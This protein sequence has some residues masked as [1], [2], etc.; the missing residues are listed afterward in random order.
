M[1]KKVLVPV[2][3]GTEMV[4]ALCIVDVFRRAGIQVDIASVHDLLFTSS[5]GVKIYADKLIS[6]CVGEDYD[7][8][9]IPGG[10]PGAEHLRDSAELTEML[11]KQ[12]SAG[13]LYGAI[14]ASPAVVLGSHGLL[15]G[16]KATC[17]PA[18]VSDLSSEQ[19]LENNVVL[20][21]NCITSRGAGTSVDF[22]LE[23]LEQLLGKEKR[24]EVAAAMV[25]S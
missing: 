2:A 11:K 20:D 9:A 18:F 22:A 13:K 24:K 5:H 8:I 14:C 25:V 4:E 15:D 23:L 1:G 19:A 6:E 7:M 17:H 21:N 12:N 10:I 16:K 3:D